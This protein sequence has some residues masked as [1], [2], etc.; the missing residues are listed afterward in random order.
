MKIDYSDIAQEYAQY[1][2]PDRAAVERLVVGSGI[3]P[4]SRVLEIG[5]GTGNYIAEIQRRIGCECAGVDPSP[6]MIAQARLGHPRA[7][8]YIASAE[9]LPLPERA[10]HLAFSVDVIHHVADRGAYFRE[11]S[12]VLRC[13]GLL[14]TLTDCEDTI[15]RR[16]PLAFYFPETIEAELRRYP[17]A[18]R[19]ETLLGASGSRSDRRGNRRNA[20]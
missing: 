12:R 4:T 5:C 20:L 16:M 10:F 6:G 7:A 9:R 11:A 18:C 8:Y 15:R 2:R 19:I 17:C 1:R 3:S 13:D 14:A